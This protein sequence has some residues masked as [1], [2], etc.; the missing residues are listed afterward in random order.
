MR[1]AAS[2]IQRWPSALAAFGTILA[3]PAVCGAAPPTPAPP[4]VSVD[5]AAP[6]VSPAAQT[7]MDRMIAAVKGLDSFSADIHVTNRLGRDSDWI[8]QKDMSLAFHRPA[9]V[10]LRVSLFGHIVADGAFIHY[11]PGRLGPERTEP[12]PATLEAVLLALA[13]G[14]GENYAVLR[15]LAGEKLPREQPGMSWTISLG[16][17]ED[18]RG[19]AIDALVMVGPGQKAYLAVGQADHLPRRATFDRDIDRKTWDLTNVKADPTL[20]MHRFVYSPPPDPFTP[21]IAHVWD[22]AIHAGGSWTNFSCTIAAFEDHGAAV[23]YRVTLRRPN[24]ARIEVIQGSRTERIVS[25]GA[26]VFTFDTTDRLHYRVEAAPTDII[27]L[28]QRYPSATVGSGGSLITM[29][30]TPAML[31]AF[32]QTR[33]TLDSLV[34]KEPGIIGGTPVDRLV[35]V[36]SDELGRNMQIDVAFG[37]EDHLARQAR[38]DFVKMNEHKVMDATAENVKVDAV[39]PDA[40]FHFD[41]PP[42]SHLLNAVFGD[43]VMSDSSSIERWSGEKGYAST[44]QPA[45]KRWPVGLCDV[46]GAPIR[47]EDLQNKVVVLCF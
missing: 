10:D 33:Y 7:V 36:P 16:P 31:K 47:Q 9:L 6:T 11:P 1:S 46:H 45:R 44:T 30:C 42:G 17:R 37:T 26:R 43:H 8:E 29:Q 20:E 35:M 38:I 32:K 25:D 22:A 12:A 4:P 19:T 27:S 5:T 23:T 21:A 40:F 18:I 2:F 3:W 24:P 34:L 13:K 41:P 15:L 39:L 28:L 14:L